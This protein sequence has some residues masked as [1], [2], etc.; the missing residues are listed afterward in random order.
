MPVVLDSQTY[1]RTSEVYRLLGISRST[2]FRWFKEG[3]AS[4]PRYRDRRGWRLFTEKEVKELKNLV[5]Q[6]NYNQA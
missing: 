5:N 3:V 6:I 2:L 4:E 1:Y